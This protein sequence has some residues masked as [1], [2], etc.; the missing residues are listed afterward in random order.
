MVAKLLA[1]KYVSYHDK[2]NGNTYDA[3]E[4]CNLSNGKE[5]RCVVDANSN[6]KGYLYRIFGEDWNQQR[7]RTYECE[8]KLGSRLYDQFTENCDYVHSFDSFCD[9]LQLAIDFRFDAPKTDL[10]LLA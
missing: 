10:D 7:A 3:I 4:V 1:V 8:T 5:S 9:W 6:I 2:Q